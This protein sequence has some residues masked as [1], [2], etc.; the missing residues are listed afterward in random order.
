MMPSGRYR[1]DV[2][3]LATFLV[4]VLVVFWQR[5]VYD[6]WLTEYDIFT[7]FLPWYG[8]LGDRLRDLDIPAWTPFFAS[9]SPMAGDPSGG[10]TYLPAMAPFALL[11]VTAAFKT[12][13]LLQIVIG[14]VSTYLLS[15]L[16]GLGPIAALTST[17]AFAFGPF[18]FGQTSF[19]T[20]AGQVTTWIPVA[21]LGVELSL[22]ASAW[23]SRAAWWSL[24][25][26]AISQIAISWPGQGLI[27]G[28]LIVGGWVAYRAMFPPTAN[29]PLRNR[30]IDALTAG[31]AV[32][33][34]GMLLGAAGLLPRLA[35]NAQSSIPGGDYSGVRGGDYLK[36]PHT[37]VTLLR[38]A[39]SD[40]AHYRPVGLSG[41]VVVLA[42]LAVLFA[43]RSYAVPF[44]AGVMVIGGILSMGET[45]LHHLFYLLPGFETIHE[46][47]PR[48]ALW[49]CSLA[50]AMLAGATVE[51]L[52]RWRER[53]GTLP[54]MIAPLLLMIAAASYL[55]RHDIWIG[56][57][58]LGTAFVTTGLAAIAVKPRL[59]RWPHRVDTAMSGALIA[60]VLLA[61]ISPAGRD[62][63]GTMRGGGT[64]IENVEK[65]CP[66][67]P[68]DTYLSRT[69]PGGAGE[70]LQHQQEMAPPFR[71]ASYAGRDPSS[72]TPPTRHA[73]VLPRC[74][75][76]CSTDAPRGLGSSRSRDTTRCM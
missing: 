18:L 54:M 52:P 3:A 28:L 8:M 40:D 43:R 46:H 32:L 65:H 29:R 47:S 62:L 27:N 23:L 22:R 37:L 53:R 12:M 2:L 7:Y 15:R 74:L 73:A 67:S 63:V 33:A 5:V 13:I 42:L 58:P 31:P 38:D 21:L 4:A 14:G 45:P 16:I 49:V 6:D 19:A 75:R 1:A 36:D 71:Y 57:W 64:G 68:L 60:L 35:V 11:G 59:D 76:S 24:A 48:R 25:G 30:L 39:L 9:G 66:T 70:Y 55:A 20:V 26:A 41:T 61:F 72:R 10:W 50:P 69:D 34:L 44:F 51:V 17:T 56:W